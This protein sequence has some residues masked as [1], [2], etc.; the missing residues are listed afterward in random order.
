[1]SLYKGRSR[2]EFYPP[3]ILRGHRGST[4]HPLDAVHDAA[5]NSYARDALNRHAYAQDSSWRLS[6]SLTR[7][8]Y[9]LSGTAHRAVS[10]R[11]SHS[12]NPCHP[13]TQ[14][15]HSFRQ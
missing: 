7:M 5:D 14:P 9:D 10:H 2:I 8:D 12:G 3:I 1:M 11:L 6:A 4:S 13:A 15:A